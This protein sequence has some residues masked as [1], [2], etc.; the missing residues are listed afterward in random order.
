MLLTLGWFNA[1]AARASR[2]QSE[3]R[4][5][6]SSET[7]NKHAAIIRG[8][9]DFSVGYDRG[10]EFVVG[11]ASIGGLRISWRGVLPKELHSSVA[12]GVCAVEHS[13]VVCAEH[14]FDNLLICVAIVVAPVPVAF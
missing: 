12:V 4:V 11:I 7:V 3:P 8:Q 14:A 9:Q 5:S 1:D 6:G 10:T 2:C 13:A